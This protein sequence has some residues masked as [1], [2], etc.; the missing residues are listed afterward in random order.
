VAS[1]TGESAW[2]FPIFE[3]GS[4]DIYQLREKDHTRHRRGSKSGV[5]NPRDK[6]SGGV[7]RKGKKGR[8]GG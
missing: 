1:R 2:T 7:R 3:F 4:R 6:G 5:K 8:E